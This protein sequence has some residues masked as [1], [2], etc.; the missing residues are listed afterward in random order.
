MNVSSPNTFINFDMALYSNVFGER[1]C[2]T[3]LDK[4]HSVDKRLQKTNLCFYADF[5]STVSCI[6][7]PPG[8]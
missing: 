2:N 6:K 8:L 1:L 7:I 3:S 5:Q 4:Y